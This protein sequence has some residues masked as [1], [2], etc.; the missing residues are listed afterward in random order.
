RVVVLG[1]PDSLVV[2]GKGRD[3]A[4]QRGVV[5]ELASGLERLGRADDPA[6]IRGPVLVA[7]DPPGDVPTVDAVEA[8]LL[9]DSRDV[10]HAS[11]SELLSTCYRSS[12]SLARC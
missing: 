3:G 2:L 11:P 10:L 9:A 8:G 1:V 6:A 4:A 7:L 12:S 5:L